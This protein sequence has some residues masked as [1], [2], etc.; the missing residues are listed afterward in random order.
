[1]ERKLTQRRDAEQARIVANLDQFAATLRDA[2]AVDDSEAE[3]ALFS[4]AE[5]SRSRDE[6][7][8][9]RRDRQSWQQR[10]DRLTV[11]RDREVAAIEARYR[12][13]QQHS[14][15]VAVIFVVPKREATR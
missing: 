2:L 10:L 11:E 6:L 7:A 9:F 8:Q 3:D 14:F 4:R 15:P 12:D 5:A 13:P 1:L